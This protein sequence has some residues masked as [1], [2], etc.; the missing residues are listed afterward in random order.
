MPYTPSNWFWIVQAHA[1]RGDALGNPENVVY[2]SAARNFV[3]LTDAGYV[4]FLGGGDVAT[5]ID[6]LASLY[7]V[8]RGDFPGGLPV[9]VPTSGLPLPTSGP[10][11]PQGPVGATGAQGSQGPPGPQ[12]PAGTDPWTYTTLAADQAISTTAL[13]NLT[14]MLFTALALTKYHVEVFGAYKSAA[15]TTGMALALDIP[16]GS[17]VGMGVTPISNTAPGSFAQITD[18]TQGSATAGVVTANANTPLFAQFI[19]SAGASGGPVQLMARS[20]V[21]ASAI[22]FVGGLLVMRWRSF[23]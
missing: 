4:A 2:S 15:T 1:Q 5:Q 7:H 22:T 11:G 17:V 3:L 16:S 9:G 12:G 8:L 20:E 21:A 14:G 13:A 19:V 10:Q 6:T 23:I 18:A